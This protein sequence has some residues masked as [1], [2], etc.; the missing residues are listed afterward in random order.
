MIFFA[1]MQGYIANE[2]SRRDSHKNNGYK[3]HNGGKKKIAP[4][5][6]EQPTVDFSNVAGG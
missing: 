5:I 1:I 4:S 2:E 6:L 3:I